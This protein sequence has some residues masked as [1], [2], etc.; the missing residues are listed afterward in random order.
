MNSDFKQIRLLLVQSV[1]VS[2]M[3]VLGLGPTVYI[4][5]DGLKQSIIS[6]CEV[7]K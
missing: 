1:I 3:E 7:E 5:H 2:F 6:I 4:P